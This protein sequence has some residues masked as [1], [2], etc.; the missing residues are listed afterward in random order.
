M[1]APKSAAFS[2]KREVP[3]REIVVPAMAPPMV[4]FTEFAVAS[5]VELPDEE[6]AVAMEAV[7]LEM[8]LLDEEAAGAMEAVFP[9]NVV[10]HF[11]VIVGEQIAPPAIC[12]EVGAF[13]LE[14]L[15]PAKT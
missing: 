3:D 13:P 6:V 7:F 5:C 12:P 4:S 11:N 15:F 2:E 8:E 10:G 14:T 1:A 9:E